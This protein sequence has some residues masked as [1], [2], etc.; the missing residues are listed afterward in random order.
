MNTK[1]KTYTKE[2][3]SIIEIL[4]GFPTI[5]NISAKELKKYKDLIARKE[6]LQKK[7]NTLLSK[8]SRII[9]TY[10]AKNRIW[11]NS[12]MN[13]RKYYKH[14]QTASYKRDLALYKLGFLDHKPS[15]PYIISLKNFFQ[16]KLFQPHSDK[17]STLKNKII[18]NL[19]SVLNNLLFKLNNKDANISSETTE[20][21]KQSYHVT[22]HNSN[23]TSSEFLSRIK[24]EPNTLNNKNSHNSNFKYYDNNS[25]F[26]IS[27]NNSQNS[28]NPSKVSSNK[29]LKSDLAL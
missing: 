3:D 1:F 24:V 8:R 21:Y 2:L 22:P 25:N 7:I 11:L 29:S 5:F 9:D 6:F 17:I 27:S 23:E 12:N 10:N 4:N 15:P 13:C 14:E 28:L 16:E 26:F 19:K 18:S 20:S